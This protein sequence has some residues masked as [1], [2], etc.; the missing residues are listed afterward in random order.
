MAEVGEDLA[1]GG[2]EELQRAA[3]EDLEELAQRDHVARP[4]QQRGLVGLLGFDVDGL[5][6]PDRVH[7]DGEVER[8]GTAREKPA[9]RSAFHCMGV[10]T[11]LR[12][13]R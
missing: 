13:P 5:I 4:V 6:A 11:P 8:A 2:V 3:A 10:R 1:V 7:D 9:L 12:S